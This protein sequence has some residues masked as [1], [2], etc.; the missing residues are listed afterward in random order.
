MLFLIK[1]NGRKSAFD[2]SKTHLR[3]LLLIRALNETVDARSMYF[4]FPD[5][6]MHLSNM[7]QIEEIRKLQ[8]LGMLWTNDFYMF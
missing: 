7:T 3:E 8:Q 6:W 4:K 1:S 2:H 5:P